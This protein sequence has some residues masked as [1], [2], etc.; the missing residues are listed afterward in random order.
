MDML[1]L[2]IIIGLVYAWGGV[3]ACTLFYTKH[4]AVLD[5]FVG[6]KMTRF[7]PVLFFWIAVIPTIWV[8]SR[9]RSRSAHRPRIKPLGKGR[10]SL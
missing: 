6:E 8:V 10:S 5:K 4:H 2:G 1:L 7:C 3:A 9:V